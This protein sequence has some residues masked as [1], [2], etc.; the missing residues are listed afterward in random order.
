MCGPDCSWGNVANHRLISQTFL[1]TQNMSNALELKKNRKQKHFH[2]ELITQVQRVNGIDISKIPHW[3]HLWYWH[4]HAFGPPG[5]WRFTLW[6]LTVSKVLMIPQQFLSSEKKKCIVSSSFLC[7]IKIKK[8]AVDSLFYDFCI[9]KWMTHSVKKCL[10][11]VSVHCHY[12][13]LKWICLGMFIRVRIYIKRS[14]FWLFTSALDIWLTGWY[15]GSCSNSSWIPC[16]FCASQNSCV[17]HYTIPSSLLM[18]QGSHF[19]I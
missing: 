16:I 7:E 14:G 18:V 8:K 3:L 12:L 1:I 13:I 4:M 15:T 2:A 9:S 5:S 11:C 6:I 17:I 10:C 19:Y